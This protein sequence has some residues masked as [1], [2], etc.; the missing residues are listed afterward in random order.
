[1][2]W[3]EVKIKFEK[4]DENGK[5]VKGSDSYLFDSVSF[6]DAEMKGFSEF[7]KIIKGSFSVEAIKKS[8]ISEVFPYED[9]D[10]WYKSVVVFETL[11]EQSG[12]EKPIKFEYLILASD[13]HKALDR[14]TDNLTDTTVDYTI[15]GIAESSIVDIYKYIQEDEN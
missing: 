9:G 13:I 12:K 1:M 2:E 8:K 15:K 7:E 6:S 10:Y 5:E 3:F 14:L 4:I 11:D